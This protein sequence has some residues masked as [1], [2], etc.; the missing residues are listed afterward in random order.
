MN[1][2]HYSGIKAERS[3]TVVKRDHR[4]YRAVENLE[5]KFR[6]RFRAKP[7]STLYFFFYFYNK[8]PNFKNYFY[9]ALL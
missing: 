9:P 5:M 1:G 2:E 7:S 8:T 3:A 6:Q 4:K